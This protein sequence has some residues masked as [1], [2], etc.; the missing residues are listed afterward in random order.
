[1]KSTTL[2]DITD[3]DALL[4]RNATW[5]FYDMF[6]DA[7]GERPSRVS[8][9][10]NTL[11]MSMT[12]CIE[13]EGLKSF[14]NELVGEMS[15]EL[16]IPITRGGS[17]TLKL[18]RKKKGLE[19]D[20]CYWVA[21]AKKRTGV[22]R[23]DLTI[24]PVPD[25]VLEI[26]IPHATVNREQ[27]Y[28]DMGVPEMWHSAHATGLT[29]STNHNAVWARLGTSLAFPS[30]AVSKI[31]S[32]VKRFKAGEDDGALVLAFRKHLQTLVTR[33]MSRQKR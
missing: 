14:I 9:D 1:M 2:R 26:D 21:N 13:R 10:G 28:A 16:H 32:V 29:A 5:A 30:V 17:S 7:L 6:T 4:F 11:K 24:H 15:R 8:F 18:K 22:K 3:T 27:I 20:A 19:P 23:L 25:L 31:N 12:L 33:I